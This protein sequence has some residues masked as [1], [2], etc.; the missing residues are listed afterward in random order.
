MPNVCRIQNYDYF[1]CLLGKHHGFRV[2]RIICILGLYADFLRI[3]HGI[4]AI[5]LRL[6]QT[7]VGTKIT[8]ILCVYW[9]NITVFVCIVCTTSQIGFQMLYGDI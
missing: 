4:S 5:L 8:I 3:L 1:V 9:A 6:C 2:H 7:F